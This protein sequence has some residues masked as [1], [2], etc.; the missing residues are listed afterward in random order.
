MF[1][2][3]VAIFVLP[4]LWLGFWLGQSA[5]HARMK[6]VGVIEYDEDGK[7][8]AKWVVPLLPYGASL[9]VDREYRPPPS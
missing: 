3:V 6:W 9:Y 5:R 4:S 8:V 7:A 1:I 2:V